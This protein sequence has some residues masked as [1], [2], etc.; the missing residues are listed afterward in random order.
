MMKQQYWKNIINIY[1]YILIIN[2]FLSDYI[3][4]SILR[5]SRKKKKEHRRGRFFPLSFN[6]TH[7]GAASML[8]CYTT[9]DS[10]I[11]LSPSF[12]PLRWRT[13]K[14]KGTRVDRTRHAELRGKCLKACIINAR[15][16]R[17]T[18]SSLM[19]ACINETSWLIHPRVNP[20][21]ELSIEEQCENESTWINQSRD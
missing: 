11:S 18:D 21:I 6:F 8:K 14:K 20:V 7:R 9:I 12:L 16:H 4:I 17:E 1:I 5:E 3:H 15:F 19:H 2:V 10:L 13:K